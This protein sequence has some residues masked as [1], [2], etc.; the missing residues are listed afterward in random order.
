MTAALL[1]NATMAAKYVIARAQTPPADGYRFPGFA[2]RMQD[3][4]P[5]GDHF[6]VFATALQYMLVQRADDAE[7]S[8]LLLPAWPCHWNVNFTVNAPK[9]T[10]ITGRVADG[11]LQYSVN[12]SSRAS[13]VHAGSCQTV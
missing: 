12:P 1:G 7:E 9:L 11:L 2:P 4:A 13:A 10:T 3:A 8:V 5:S 6:A